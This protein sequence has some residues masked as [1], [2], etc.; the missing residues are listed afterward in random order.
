MK[1]ILQFMICSA[2]AFSLQAQSD[3]L[4]THFMFNKL[5]YNPAYAGSKG[6]FDMTAIY[7][8]QW[9]DIEGAPQTANINIHT[10]FAGKK[11][12]LGFA[13][14]SD[15]IGKV[16]T[17][18]FDLTYAYRIPLSTRHTLS[19]G[20]HGRIEQAMIDWTKASP[21]DLGDTSIPT[22]DETSFAPNFGAGAYFTGQNYFVGL[23]VPRL[24]KNSLY[25]NQSGS[26]E[27]DAISY[28]LMSGVTNRL[29]SNLQLT[30]SFLLSYNPSA[31]VDVD[32]NASLHFM[33]AFWIAGN[34][35]LADSFDALAGYEFKNG[36]RIGVA[37]DFTTSD[38]EKFTKG[39]WEVMLGYTYRCKDCNVSHLRFF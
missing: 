32:L 34:Y 37:R 5:A 36:L 4:F 7:R 30:T 12:A 2:F 28:Y 13:I 22:T 21:L 10:P 26:F 23:S 16:K 11:N 8:N 20:L 33:E 3:V 6:A 27:G 38:L 39:S 14:T 18:A 19:L 24:L 35:R 9:T 15:K 17:N 1:K 29:N 31:P 25:I